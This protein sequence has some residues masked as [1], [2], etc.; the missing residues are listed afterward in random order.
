MIAILGSGFGLYGYLPA[1]VSGCGERIVLLKRYHARFC[2]RP[3]L[4]RFAQDV[5]WE[6]DEATALRCADGAVI[7]LPPIA[8]S[9]WIPQCLALPNIERLLLEKPL[10]VSPE[11]A[12][13]LSG[14]LAR[15][16][17]TVRMGYTF[18]YTAWGTGIRDALKMK[19]ENRS[20][21][22]QWNFR[23]HHFRHDLRNWKRFHVS[24]GGP[25]RFYGIQLIALLA[26][27]GYCDVT[28]SRS[29]GNS[30]DEIEK[31]TAS[32]AG[33]GLPECDAVVNTRASVR[34]FRVGLLPNSGTETEAEFANQ[35]DPFE[36]PSETD[37]LEGLD[38][39]VPALSRLCRSLWEQ[40]VNDYAWY[41]AVIELWRRIEEKTHFE[42]NG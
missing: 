29:F 8:Q 37:S 27:I 22:I 18:R 23:A 17:K 39:R 33:P 5:Q 30:P 15:S 6:R 40:S 20:L 38:R 35:A 10:A 7:A 11:I 32:F 25:I 16:G 1:L 4:A 9:E 12:A 19:K 13:G 41:D 42:I 26:E 34:S 28:S 14:D 24:G 21:S 31:W 36:S 2:E 3:E